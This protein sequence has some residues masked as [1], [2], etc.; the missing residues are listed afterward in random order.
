MATT[1]A[2]WRSQLVE[3]LRL[4]RELVEESHGARGAAY[5]LS[6]RR[7]RGHGRGHLRR[8]VAQSLHGPRE[9]RLASVGIHEREDAWDADR[10]EPVEAVRVVE[11]SRLDGGA[12]RACGHVR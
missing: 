12:R 5:C 7:G 4:P 10:A 6:S 2:A 11:E 1:R 9:V 3:R 8:V